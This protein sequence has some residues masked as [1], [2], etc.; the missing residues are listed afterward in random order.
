VFSD[1]DGLVALDDTPGGTH[2]ATE[3]SGRWIVVIDEA[4]DERNWDAQAADHDVVGWLDPLDGNAASWTTDH[5]P[6]G[7]VQPAGASCLEELVGVAR[8]AVGFQEAVLGLPINARDGDL[9]DSIPVFARFD[10][11]DDLDFPGPAI[12]VDADNAGVVVANGTALFR[13]DEAAD[14]FDWNDDGDKTD[15]VLFRS[16]VASSGATFFIGTLNNLTR[17][18]VVADPLNVGAAFLADEAAAGADLNL[19]G[20]QNDFVVRFLRVGP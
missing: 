7:G 14:N 2:G 6:S 13:V 18:A 3:L 17:P 8:V 11:A 16:D 19:D 10:P 20:D 4:A 5:S 9:L 1:V 12:A 15:R